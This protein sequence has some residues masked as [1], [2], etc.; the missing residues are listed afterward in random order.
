MSGSGP[1]RPRVPPVSP[2]SPASPG[3]R[4]AAPD[5]RAVIRGHLVG[6]GVLALALVL[7]LPLLSA[8]GRYSSDQLATFYVLVVIALACHLAEWWD[9]RAPAS[10]AGVIPLPPRPPGPLAA[11]VRWP[12]QKPGERR[13]GVLAHSVSEIM[14]SVVVFLG[15]AFLLLGI[16]ELIQGLSGQAATTGSGTRLSGSDQVVGG[17]LV[18][19]AAGLSLAAAFVGVERV[20]LLG[21]RLRGDR[22]ISWFAILV[23]TESF[24][25]LLAPTS[26]AESVASTIAHPAGAADLVAGSLPFGVIALL[27][28]GPVVDRSPG[29]WVR[30]L[31]VL[32]LRP[33]WLLVGIGVGLLL[34][35]TVD[36]IFTPLQSHL[37]PADCAVQQ[38]QVEQ[39]L[40]G[41]DT[42]RGVLANLA[43]ALAAG[44]DE[45]LIFRGVVQP[46]FGLVLTSFLFGAFHLQY[47]CHGLPS[48]GD[49]EIVVLGLA[50][51]T[52][53]IRGGVGAAILAHAAYDG[54][55]LVDRVLPG[56]AGLAF[57]PLAG[58]LVWDLARGRRGDATALIDSGR[59][60][61]SGGE[62]A[63]GGVGAGGPADAAQGA[64]PPGERSG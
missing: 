35:P 53:R 32:P 34:V 24:A 33:V 44:V 4:G 22:P 3:T 54:S 56:V 46:R 11:L 10:G 2:A 43:I 57:L 31:G 16:L 38:M 17:G 25:Q 18:A 41:G 39:S 42:G 64:G 36:W 7:A 55:I 8:T 63:T 15:I 52:L 60:A 61:A 59:P 23:V 12:A 26:G 9:T 62:A 14:R 58:Y 21:R 1:R 13:L 20:P 45:E 29:E 40:A 19:V 47:T 6:S 37:L 5:G 51:G 50:F 48:V 49:L 30:R 28:V 27:A